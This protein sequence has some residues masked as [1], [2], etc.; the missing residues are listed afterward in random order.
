M[1]KYLNM[2]LTSVIILI[3]GYY[4]FSTP[5]SPKSGVKKSGN[6]PDTV[7]VDLG[8][9]IPNPNIESLFIKVEITL[10]DTLNSPYL[11]TSWLPV[12]P[13]T[14][15]VYELKLPA[16]LLKVFWRGLLYDGIK[17]SSWSGYY[18]FYLSILEG[19][20]VYPI[21]CRGCEYITFERIPS[22]ANLR[23]HNILGGTVY[24]YNNIKAG[25]FKWYLTDKVGYKV[26]SG[27]Y[28]YQIRYI[29]D[30]KIEIAKGK[31][32]ITK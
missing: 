31:L 10:W 24:T 9:K 7:I 29:K 2:F 22:G 1:L 32:I 21:P 12:G 13:D 30:H 5:Q 14:E 26:S 8:F 17:N 11:K 15:F 3:V 6:I 27:I 18:Y 4:F 28:I 16:E 25:I 23:I 20:K 19:I